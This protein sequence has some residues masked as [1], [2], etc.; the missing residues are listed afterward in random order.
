MTA[1][2]DD[3]P[4]PAL[5]PRHWPA[6]IDSLM[7]AE[8]IKEIIDGWVLDAVT[9]GETPPGPREPVGDPCE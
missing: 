4:I 8:S 9:E 5:L 1:R 7:T 2:E 6:V 3:D